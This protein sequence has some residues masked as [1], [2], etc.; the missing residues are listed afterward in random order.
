MNSIINFENK[1]SQK[2]LNSLIKLNEKFY[3]Q[4]GKINIVSVFLLE[5]YKYLDSSA[6]SII[7]QS[8]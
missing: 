1:Q 2:I 3:K 7:N 6:K 5:L 8:S 4:F